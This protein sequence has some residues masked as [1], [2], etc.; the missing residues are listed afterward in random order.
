[1]K[2]IILT[3]S[4]LALTLSA[5]AW[6]K[7]SYP[8]LTALASKHLTPEA[9]SGTKATLGGGLASIAIAK[10]QL[11]LLYLNEEYVPMGDGGNDALAVAN[12]SIE[13]LKKDKNDKEALLSL[14]KAVVDMHA[15]ANVR[16]KGNSF[17]EGKFTVRRWNN[18][19]G[20]MARYKDSTWKFLWDSY[21]AY[22]H[23]IFTAEQYAEDID[24]YHIARLDEFKKGTPE[25]WAKD[26]AAEVRVIYSREL[27]DNLILRQE[28]VNHLEF[29]HDRLLAKA[30]Y[31][32]AIILNEI[33]K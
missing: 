22:R 3:L 19:N 4:L 29:T 10:E 26:M 27:S 6:N 23:A 33:Y 8:A 21:Y 11:C 7:F 2:K 24:L 12:A 13:R 17:S 30:A 32:L 16:V 25:E 28:D 20:K 18:R 9:V 5:G 14:A 31:R 15:V 1:M